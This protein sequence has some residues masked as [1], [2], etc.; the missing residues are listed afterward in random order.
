M[1]FWTSDG[2]RRTCLARL[3]KLRKVGAARYIVRTEQLILWSF[4]Q[5]RIHP[6]LLSLPPIRLPGWKD[7]YQKFIAK[8]EKHYR[9]MT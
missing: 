5:Y 4:R 2:A 3:V 1:D 8:Y 7:N 6:E 9:R